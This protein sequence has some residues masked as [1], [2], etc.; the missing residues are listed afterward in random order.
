MK[1][2]TAT[3]ASAATTPEGEGEWPLGAME[4]AIRKVAARGKGGAS[5]APFPRMLRRHFAWFEAQHLEHGLTWEG[6]VEVLRSCGMRGRGGIALTARAA[7]AAF[8]REKARRSAGQRSEVPGE[9][10]APSPAMAEAVAAQAGPRKLP[11]LTGGV[12]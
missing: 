2:T 9:R 10:E 5:R 11:R 6:W 4:A 3:T 7:R 1:R 8:Q 12:E